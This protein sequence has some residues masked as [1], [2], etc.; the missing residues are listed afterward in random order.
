VIERYTLPAMGALWSEQAR[1]ERFV[2][3]ELAVTRARARRGLVPEA[4]LR[5]IEA[6][7]PSFRVDVTMAVDRQ[8]L[9]GMA[10]LCESTKDL[11]P[12]EQASRLREYF[13]IVG[14]ARP[15]EGRGRK[16]KRP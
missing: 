1:F 4:D 14:G 7:G 10:G 8:P 12:K 15:A 5:A 3:V 2:R 13:G 16:G 11:P 6:A 9:G